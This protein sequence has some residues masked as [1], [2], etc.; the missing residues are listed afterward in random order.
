MKVWRS[1]QGRQT[2]GPHALRILHG[3]EK[4]LHRIGDRRTRMTSIGIRAHYLDICDFEVVVELAPGTGLVVRYGSTEDEDIEGDPEDRDGGAVAHLVV[5]TVEELQSTGADQ[6]ADILHGAR[7]RTRQILAGWSAE[8]T[9]VVLRG[10]RFVREE[11]PPAA[12]DLPI[13]VALLGLDRTLRPAVAWQQADHPDRLDAALAK[14]R[15]EMDRRYEMHRVL[16]RQGADGLVDQLVVNAIATHM[17]VGAALRQIASG[18]WPNLP[19]NLT[20]FDESDRLSCHGYDPWNKDFAWN[21]DKLI[22][23]GMTLPATVLTAKFGR[24]VTQLVTHAM[25]SDDMTIL[26]AS[27]H[28][29]QFGHSITV[30][31]D[32]PRLAFCGASGR[33]WRI[34]PALGAMPSLG[35]VDD[36]AE[37]R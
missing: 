4:G 25:L 10:I 36:G 3:V 32:Q 29:N 8:G 23:S 15:P 20:V 21:R 26:D 6:L 5:R 37:E 33:V 9:N 17:D 11:I 27:S 24:P 28:S 22:I 19:G 7:V 18:V 30:T 16:S 2:A 12:G 1:N 14:L 13:E 34:D 31:I 35:K